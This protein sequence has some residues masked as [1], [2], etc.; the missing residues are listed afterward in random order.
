MEPSKHTK[1]FKVAGTQVVDGWKAQYR[2]GYPI[3]HMTRK[4]WYPGMQSN[5]MPFRQGTT[6]RKQ[7]HGVNHLA[8]CRCP[9]TDRLGPKGPFFPLGRYYCRNFRPGATEHGVAANCRKH[10][11]SRPLKSTFARPTMHVQGTRNVP[12]STTM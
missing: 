5:Q 10:R 4:Y 6:R 3:L 2:I 8:I 11:L 12:L 7:N 9:V 1:V